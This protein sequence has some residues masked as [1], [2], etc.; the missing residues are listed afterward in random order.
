M[1]DRAKRG[2]GRRGGAVGARALVFVLGLAGPARATP[3]DGE[4][5]REALDAG[6]ARLD[7]GA[8]GPVCAP[9]LHEGDR[10]AH[11]LDA[12]LAALEARGH[13]VARAADPA[14]ANAR[15]CATWLT[16]DAGSDALEVR[17]LTLARARWTG[18]LRPDVRLVIVA[19]A[20][21]GEASLA[22]PDRSRA[23]PS[24]IRALAACPDGTLAIVD[25]TRLTLVDRGLQ[26]IRAL[27]LPAPPRTFVRSRVSRSRAVCE[28]PVH[29]ARAAPTAEVTFGHG[30]HPGLFV[31]R[32]GATPSLTVTATTAANLGAEAT[33]LPLA[34]I[35]ASEGVDAKLG[36]AGWWVARVERGRPLL[37]ALGVVDAR[38]EVAWAPLTRAAAELA[39]A[40]RASPR[41]AAAV[42][43]DGALVQFELASTL[44]ATRQSPANA[45]AK[46]LEAT[47]GTRTGS[48]R[49]P[50][51]LGAQ[52]AVDTAR[53]E[54]HATTSAREN[55][56]DHVVVD[57]ETWLELEG[58]VTALALDGARLWVGSVGA[59]GARLTRITRSDL[60][61][62]DD[63]APRAGASSPRA[64]GG[65][66]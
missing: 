28:F 66:P 64:P 49:A 38:G 2:P 7:L 62:H 56:R 11:A 23:W 8:A 63:E 37:D 57:G 52:L 4:V 45:L 60:G 3:T 22:E 43:I 33:A 39:A 17:L 65:R 18:D 24:P 20:A 9:T 44:A 15:G 61:A 19:T 48:A 59:S 34:R 55:G 16:V 10:H 35:A 46:P 36:A 50:P 53:P 54:R 40:T 25:D 21:L 26:P 41:V 6:L 32:L 31:A 1:R 13:P 12:A 29:R 5:P 51:P 30:A 14:A 47:R 58:A 42:T 27:A